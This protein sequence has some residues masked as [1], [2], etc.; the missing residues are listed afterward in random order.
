MPVMKDALAINLGE[1]EKRCIQFWLRLSLVKS[2]DITVL[3][4][5]G[6]AYGTKQEM[7]KVLYR[8]GKGASACQV[9]G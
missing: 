4:L 7:L 3:C 8:T 2:D 9:F 1:A 6:R 5:P